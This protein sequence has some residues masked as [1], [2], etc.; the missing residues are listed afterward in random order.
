MKIQCFILRCLQ[1]MMPFIGGAVFFSKL[2][3]Y[4]LG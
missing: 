1:S 3:N 4:A 2:P